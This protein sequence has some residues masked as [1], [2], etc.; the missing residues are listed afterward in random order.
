LEG[1]EIIITD[2]AR[3]VADGE[4]IEIIEG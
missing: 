2:G 3:S 1:S 4:L